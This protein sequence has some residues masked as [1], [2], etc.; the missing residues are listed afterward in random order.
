MKINILILNIFLVVSIV[1][2]CAQQDFNNFKTLKS[3]GP[4]PNDFSALTYE[5]IDEDLKKTKG[6][7]T[8]GQ[9]KIFLQGIHYG[10]DDILHSGMVVYGD[11]IS[12]YIQLIANKLLESNSK[13]KSELRFYTLKSNESNAFSTDQ[14]M[15]F[16]T[17]GLISQLT[18]EAQLAF[19]LAHEISHYTE[20]H[21]V[22]TFEY[23]TKNKRSTNIRGLSIYSK[24]KEFEADRLGL[25]LYNKAGYSKEELLPSFDVLMYSYLPFDEVEL[26]KSYFE[27]A[28]LFVPESLFPNKK[29]EIKAVEDYDDSRSSH[30]NIKKRK[31]QIENEIDKFTNWEDNIFF[32][33]QSKFEY[34]R[35]IC[36]FESVRTDILDANYAD[37]I[38]SI[39][40]LE[41]EYPKS[42]YLKRMKAQTWLGLAQYKKNGNI[43]ETVNK[44][45]DLEGE[46][47]A[48]HFFI[49]KL[50]KD[51][52][53]TIA[54]RQ[55]YDL[56]KESPEDKQLLAIY[57]YMLKEL[58]DLKSFKLESFSK[59]TFNEAAHD[60]IEKKNSVAV[61]DTASNKKTS[62]KYDKIKSK[63]SAENPDNF[64]STKFYLYG[65]SDLINDSLFIKEY[66]SHKSISLE[67]EKLKEDFDK[68]SYKEQKAK[69][70]LE[71]E[72]K[73]KLNA[74]ELIVVEPMVFSYKK[75]EI[76]L[77]KSEKLKHNFSQII[78]ESATEAG[79]K[80]Y[81]ID[82]DHLAV[83][84][85]E[86]YN[87][88]SVL[89]SFMQQVS[90]EDNF[91]IFPVDYEYLQ[92]IKTNYGTQRVMFT[93]VESEYDA[94]ID[95]FS[96]YLATI[97]YPS[98][99]IYLPMKLMSGHSTEINLIILDVEKGKIEVGSNYYIKDTPKKYHLG[100]HMFNLF[101]K[102]GSS[103]SV[104]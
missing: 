53:L 34:I 74:K 103:K 99:P 17:T 64:D 95:F 82:R 46:I 70:K 67:E 35:N 57:D 41:K 54:L 6:N 32:F 18:N 49:K 33:S 40:L 72:E 45:S 16:V 79:V 96:M 81:S 85:T 11:E 86:V 97:F 22:E 10:I 87:E 48:V 25:E 31:E 93:W 59:K 88:R 78:E 83:K 102:I 14:G 101:K 71:E 42:I 94:N 60:F 23:H 29:Y 8:Y 4:I 63:K 1:N 61:L 90:R 15:I 75:G 73:L 20:K 98:L 43:N 28:Y 56:K 47:A 65:I 62:S 21:V 27:S 26:P 7:L 50:S 92:E 39:F 66:K 36:R 13:L 5:K 2:V 44:N 24:E 51:G 9:E 52:L 89:F 55:I 12:E 100:A 104:N 58:S 80:V 91:N 19:V 69:L 84:G 30:P 76:D 68:L 3:V 77:L 37:A 38:Y